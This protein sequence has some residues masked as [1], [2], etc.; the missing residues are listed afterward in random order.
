MTAITLDSQV[1]RP[2]TFLKLKALV[3][4]PLRHLFGRVE[5][6][7]YGRDGV[8][9]WLDDKPVRCAID[10]APVFLSHPDH[11][12]DRLLMQR[13]F[14]S[15]GP[16]DAFLD[17][18]S[19]V[20]LY[21]IGAAARVGPRGHVVAFEPTPATVHKLSRNLALNQLSDRVV[22]EEV[23]VSDAAGWV[24]FTTTGTSMMN[25]IF[26]GLPEGH[27]RPGGQLQSIQVR[28][29]RLDDYVEPGRRTTAKI[30]TEGHE[31]AVLRGATNLLASPAR[32]FVELH[33]WA[34]P[35]EQDVWDELVD[36]CR[37]HQRRIELLDGTAL[38]HP[39]HRRVEF[40]L[41]ASAIS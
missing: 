36:M 37:R 12:E 1:V 33:P 31:L 7:F 3:P 2:G 5:R 6:Y 14:E 28:T 22:I 41:V 9:V 25:S 38:D 32:I 10:A 34:W 4:G 15:L 11:A 16:G 29:A 18:G 21:A 39:A 24:E 13:V 35:S 40:A 17:V 20:G 8:C 30:D 19:H 26:A 27:H 23:A